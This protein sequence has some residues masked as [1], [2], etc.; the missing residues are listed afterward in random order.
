MRL[1]AD[2]AAAIPSRFGV[3]ELRGAEALCH[4]FMAVE[5]NSP[6]PP[7]QEPFP[8]R[9]MRS[10]AGR[11]LAPFHRG[12]HALFLK[13]LDHVGVAGKTEFLASEDGLSRVW[14]R[15]LVAA[16]TAALPEGGVD[17]RFHEGFV[18]GS[19]GTVTL[20]AVGIRN[21]K[22]RV[23]SPDLWLVDVVAVAAELPGGTH[24]Q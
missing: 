8:L 23:G 5:T 4:P 18:V 17:D 6:L 9:G 11:A 7:G 10:V 14:A 13:L 19:V 1:V 16:A 24:Q 21:R 22:R 3:I 15:D 12:M 2:G 20:A